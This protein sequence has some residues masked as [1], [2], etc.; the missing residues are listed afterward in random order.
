V[1]KTFLDS[2]P[3]AATLNF[4]EKQP[5]ANQPLAALKACQTILFQEFPKNIEIKP[6]RRL[7]SY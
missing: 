4:P 6:S 1:E 3:W 5:M 2:L 7:P